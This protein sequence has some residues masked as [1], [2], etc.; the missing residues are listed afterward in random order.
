MEAGEDGERREPLTTAPVDPT[1]SLTRNAILNL[2]GL[3]A[4]LLVALFAIPPL[5][6]ELGT[7]R[8]GILT[9]IWVVLGYF[10]LFDLG[11]GRAVTQ[12]VSGQLS[13][14]QLENVPDLIWTALGLMLALGLTTALAVAGASGLLVHALRVPAQL[15]HETL[16]SFYL[17]T[18]SIP[19]V[20]VTT[21]LRGI[22]EANHRFDLVTW[23][24]APLGVFTYV[25]PLLV[26][27]FGQGLVPVVAILIVGRAIALGVHVIMC[28][29][30]MPSLRGR[31]RLDFA[32]VPRLLKLGSWMSVSNLVGPMLVNI[33]RF[34][35]GSVIS[36][37]VVAYYTVPFELATKVLLLPGALAGVLFPAFA[38]TYGTDP[39]RSRRLFSQGMK[40]TWLVLFPI[41]VVLVAFAHEGLLLWLGPEF[42]AKSARVLQWLAVG[43]LINSLA[44]VSFALVQGAGRPDLTAKLHI[45]ELPFYFLLLWWLIRRYGVDGAAIAWT[46][47]ASVDAVALF[48]LVRHPLGLALLPLRRLAVTATLGILSLAFLSV[49][50]QPALRAVMAGLTVLLFSGLGWFWLFTQDERPRLR[51]RLTALFPRN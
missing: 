16:Q 20:M 45:L 48:G 47:R 51:G 22:L 3:V 50:W 24:R 40:V 27:P 44:Q 7:D 17:L 2:F 49:E 13:R 28:R 4:P 18:I 19:I 6:R 29:R 46:L 25:G 42:A 36:V 11:L 12:I 5:T 37:S 35:L 9:L 14:G 23:I 26:I 21:G 1:P 15:E 38:G 41:I 34:V 32:L 10:S 8:F 31:P 30:V 43:V 39:S 33:D